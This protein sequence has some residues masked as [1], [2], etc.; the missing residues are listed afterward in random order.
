M[1]KTF[2]G[3]MFLGWC[4]AGFAQPVITAIRPNSDTIGLF[5]K[6]EA[7]FALKAEYT[8]PFDPGQIDITAEFT[9]PSG[10]SWSINGFYSEF[11][12]GNVESPVLAG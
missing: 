4:A 12:R 3:L 6:F 1:K 8:N 9:S 10:Q 2:I 7:G 11:F 5:D